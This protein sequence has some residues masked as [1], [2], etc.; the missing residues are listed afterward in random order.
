[1]L[2]HFV[3]YNVGVQEGIGQPTLLGKNVYIKDGKIEKICAV[4][5]QT[6]SDLGAANIIDGSGKTLIPGLVF[7]HTHIAYDSVCGARDVLFK[8][9][10]TRLSFIAA[11]VAKKAAQ[12]GYTTMVGAGSVAC[13]DTYLKEAIDSGLFDG[14]NLIPCSR[15]IMAAGPIGS[16]NKEKVAHIPKDYMPVIVDDEEINQVV[17]REIDD[18]AKIIKTFATGDDQFPN[19]RSGEELFSL[20]ELKQIVA[21]AHGRSTLVRC[22]ARGLSGIKNAIA[23]EVDIIDHCSYADQESLDLIQKNNISIVP[24]FYQPLQYIACGSQYGR[25]PEES[26]FHLEVENTMSFLPKAEAMGIN[27][28]VGDDFG[29]AWTPHGT[30][31]QELIAFQEKLN[32]PAVTIIKWATSNGAKMIGANQ[33]IGQLRDGMQA[34]MIL[35]GAD[36]SLDIH[37]LA[38]NIEKVFIAGK[39][40]TG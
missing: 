35:L 17:N 10:L 16:R 31:H 38:N 18:G 5:N 7:A 39:C 20:A 12:L 30:Y 33:R 2:S 36:P 22:H 13:I 29:F 23:A 27:I 9:P 26:D 1:M 25:H 19:A 37:A 6:I 11:K 40:I 3:I 32:I 21:I 15:D 28:A 14:P 24:S 8:H 4:N 34:D